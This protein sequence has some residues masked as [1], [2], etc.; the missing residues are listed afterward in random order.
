MQI[1]RVISVSE[2]LEF[3]S[4]CRQQR[5]C[6][7]IIKKITLLYGEK[8]MSKLVYLKKNTKKKAFFMYVKSINRDWGPRGGLC[9]YKL[10]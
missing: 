1:S 5:V 4:R 7:I 6:Y 9:P 2:Q 3:K 8:I 10:Y